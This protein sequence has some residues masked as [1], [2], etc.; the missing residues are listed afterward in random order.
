MKKVLSYGGGVQTFGML[1][2]IEKGI[3]EKPDFAIFADTLAEY[4]ETYHHIENVAKPI[5]ERLNIPF[6]EVVEDKGIIEGYEKRN[7]IPMPGFRS[8]TANFKVKPIHDYLRNIVGKDLI[9]KSRGKPLIETW[10]GIST[11]ESSREVKREKQTP[12]W[13]LQSYPLL[14]KDISR[15]QII[16]IIEKSGYEMPRKSGCFMCPY[17]G[18]KGF[19]LLKRD[20]QELY[21]IAVRMEELY[22]E[23]RP[24]RR[25]GFLKDSG[26]K[27]KELNE[28][29]TLFSFV[30][31][32]PS[33]SEC[34]SGGCFL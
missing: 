30:D 26:L 14:E 9:R 32:L 10:I 5:F 2:M 16:E 3:L 12:K 27:L 11:D 21:S 15:R 17:Q 7:T 31:E 28:I 23:N 25:G 13:V 8:C 22:F 6:I 34:E 1:V 20:Y 24:S 18:L 33:G 29:P 4:P 19:V